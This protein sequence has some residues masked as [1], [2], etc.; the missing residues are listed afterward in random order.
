MTPHD[1]EAHAGGV[2]GHEVAGHAHPGALSPWD[3]AVVAGLVALAFV[4]ARG[5]R[6]RGSAPAR[7]LERSA[8]WVGWLTLMVAVL[9][10][11][12]QMA[13]ERFSAHMAQHELMMLIAVPLLIAGRAF[14]VALAGVP[15]G[16][17]AQTLA[18][19]Q[20][21]PAVVSWRWATFPLVAWLVHG[22]TIWV[23]HLPVLYDA[24]VAHEGLHA[25]QH[26]TFVGSAALFW[27]GL[28]QGRYGRI[29]YGAAV[30]FVFTTAMH[31]GILGA[32]LTFARRPLY[33]FYAGAAEVQGISPLED[34][35]L[36]GVLMWMPAGFVFTLLGVALF[37][38]WLG[39]SQR[40]SERAGL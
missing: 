22:L 26:A 16:L 34:Q 15:V 38:A 32:L 36:A 24:A 31:T 8:F 33:P 10:P 3:V 39:E 17:R 25:V 5:S 27:W 28:L 9:P 37:A 7:R 11:L 23:W 40:R 30:L 12:D 2:H 19:L 35:Q 13:V 18:V 1:D 4:Y 29:G 14:P 21:R 6:R 20:W